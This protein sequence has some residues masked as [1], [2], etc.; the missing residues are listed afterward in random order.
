MSASMNDWNVGYVLS[1]D[2][3]SLLEDSGGLTEMV[4]V[5]THPTP[6]G[7]FSDPYAGTYLLQHTSGHC[8]AS[9]PDVSDPDSEP[10]EIVHLGQAESDEELIAMLTAFILADDHEVA[11]AVK[12]HFDAADFGPEDWFW[13]ALPEFYWFRLSDS[14]S[15]LASRLDLALKSLSPLYSHLAAFFDNPQSPE[16]ES[17][18]REVDGQTFEALYSRYKYNQAEG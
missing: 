1:E 12:F 4:A 2:E 16:F 7:Y 17:L 5:T 11:A 9:I 6:G 14:L 10:N 8:F 13:Q 18:R 3:V 15:Q